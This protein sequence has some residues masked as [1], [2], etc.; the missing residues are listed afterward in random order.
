MRYF[1][2]VLVFF[3]CWLMSCSND[4]DQ[5]PPV[6]ELRSPEM[7]GTAALLFTIDTDSGQDIF[8]IDGYELDNFSV[9]IPG[10]LVPNS[11]VESIKIDDSNFGFLEI[12][13]RNFLTFN[14]QNDISTFYFDFGNGD[15][16][17]LSLVNNNLLAEFSD[18][19][20]T[21]EV[22]GTIEVFYN[23]ELSSSLILETGGTLVEQIY[24]GNITRGFGLL[25]LRNLDNPLTVTLNKPL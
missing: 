15:I 19:E 11:G 20:P 18:L 3:V 4:S 13:G 16:D 8:E 5:A 21:P 7:S 1:V 23:G 17:T 6:G 10:D 25:A 12:Q 2:L 24:T 14:F 9:L 22:N